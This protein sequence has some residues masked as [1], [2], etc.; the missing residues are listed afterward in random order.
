MMEVDEII[1]L[2][3]ILLLNSRNIG[4]GRS[5]AAL[6]RHGDRRTVFDL[7]LSNSATSK[8]SDFLRDDTNVRDRLG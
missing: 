2:R 6:G 4:G 7:E 8:I 5:R 3:E 1:L